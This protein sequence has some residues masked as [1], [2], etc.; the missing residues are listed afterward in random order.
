MT[1]RHTTKKQEEHY[2]RLQTDVDKILADYMHC[3]QKNNGYS[4]ET[5]FD[6]DVD[7]V[8]KKDL[9]KPSLHTKYHVA[10]KKAA[11]ELKNN[12]HAVQK[13][14]LNQKPIHPLIERTS[15]ILYFFFKRFE[16]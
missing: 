14:N 3:F 1:E 2:V 13:S 9:P 8:L 4:A 12:T 6:L 10:E 15:Q 7:V 11:D 5:C 16:Y